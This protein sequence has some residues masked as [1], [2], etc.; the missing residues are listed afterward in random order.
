VKAGTP[1][2]SALRRSTIS[3]DDL[4]EALR[5]RVIDEMKKVKAA[6]L[7]RDEAITAVQVSQ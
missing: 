4:Q 5:L 6:Y 1:N 7:E 3:E 2:A